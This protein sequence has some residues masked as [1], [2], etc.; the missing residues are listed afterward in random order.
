MLEKL[1]SY[2]LL[3]AGAI[4]SILMVMLNRKKEQV[5]DL[6]V[7]VQTSKTEKEIANDLKEATNALDNYSLSKLK[8]DAWKNSRNK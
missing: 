4:V 6:E 2:A 8:Y 5:H 1:K 7:K 3:I